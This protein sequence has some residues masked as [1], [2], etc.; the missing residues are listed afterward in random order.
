MDLC[1]VDW[2]PL[3]CSDWVIGTQSM[4]VVSL[5][6]PIWLNYSPL[7]PSPSSMQVDQ[8]LLFFGD[9]LQL[10]DVPWTPTTLVLD[11]QLTS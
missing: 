1:R 5:S 9:P 10:V 7:L 11:W 3:L 6:V 8:L 2:M 4:S